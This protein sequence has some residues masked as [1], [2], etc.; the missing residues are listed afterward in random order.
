M[1]HTQLDSRHNNNN[2]YNVLIEMD[3]DII[4]LN[5]NVYY[6]KSHPT[7]ILYPF[8]FI[9]HIISTHFSL[10]HLRSAFTSA[11]LPPNGLQQPFINDDVYSDGFVFPIF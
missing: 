5:T 4:K 11:V 6:R 9:I 1:P 10:K 8:S 2:S 7:A 3:L